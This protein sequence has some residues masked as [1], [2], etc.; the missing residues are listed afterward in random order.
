MKRGVS[1]LLA[2]LIWAMLAAPAAAWAPQGHEIIAAIARAHLTPA[3]RSRAASLLGGDSMIVLVASWADEVRDGR[4]ETAPWHYVDIPLDAKA[5]DARRDC[6]GGQCV[7]A[8]IE[9]EAR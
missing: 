8:Q 2:G 6:P 9:G 1:H 4:P 5:Y 7:V 3:A